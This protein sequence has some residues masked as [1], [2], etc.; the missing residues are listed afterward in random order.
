MTIGISPGDVGK[1]SNRGGDFTRCGGS[2]IAD[3]FGINGFQ[4]AMHTCQQLQR[5]IANL[6]GTMRR[7]MN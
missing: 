7:R 5:Y 2:R 1:M 6:R 4:E 3:A